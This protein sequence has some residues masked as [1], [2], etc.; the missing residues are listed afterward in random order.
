LTRLWTD[1]T[2]QDFGQVD[3]ETWVAL[4]PVAAVEQHGPHLPVSVDA[5]I[6]AGVV[7]EAV[8]RLGE[9]APVVV[10]PMLPIGK[11]NE[12]MAFP[13][14]LTLRLE[15]LVGLWTDVAESVAR[16]GFRKLVFLNSHGGQPQVVDIVARDLRVRLGM[17][18]VAA[19]T[20]G[21]GLPDGLFSD[22][23]SRFG[24]HAGEIETSMMMHLRG[25][26]VRLDKLADFPS[27]AADIEEEFSILQAEGAV[28][29]GWMTQD[30]NA[31]GAAGDARNA[32]AERGRLCV[33]FAAEKLAILLR[34]VSRYPLD[35]LK[36][37]P[38]AAAEACA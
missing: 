27:A 26:A 32:D 18:A 5:D 13:G 17:L 37:G 35:R 25:P 9:D 33:E 15:T 34:E 38:L 29:L 4:L 14:T 28:G 22:R 21:F 23:E 19:H 12:H 31:A 16:A 3:P 1:M 7:A 30:L 10:L 8:R 36:A 20:Y 11:S 6:N 24:I 2:S